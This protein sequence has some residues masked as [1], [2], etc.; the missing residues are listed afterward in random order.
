MESTKPIGIWIRVSTEDQAQGESPEHHEERARAYAK[1]MG[2]EVKTVYHL[3]AVSGKAVMHHNEAK[4]MLKDVKNGSITGLVFSKLARLARNTKELLEIADIF[5]AH[6]ASLISLQEKIDTG[7]AAG[8]LFYTIIAAMAQWEREEISSRVAASVQIRAQLGKPLGGAAPYGYRWKG[9]ELLL[10][11]H[12]APIRK[13]M[14][15]LYIV[16]KRKQVVCTILN[17]KGYRTRN[18]ALF[19]PTTLER[20]LRDPMAKGERRANYTKSLG[21]KKHWKVKD[22]SEWVM[23]SCPAIITE[24][25]YN[26]TIAILDQFTNKRTVRPKKAVYLFSGFL[27]CHCGGKMYVPSRT[28]KYVCSKCNLTSIA[29]SDI[30]EIYYENLKSF[31]LTKEDLETFKNRANEAIG[32]KKKLMDSLKKDKEK[33]K[34]EI[35]S[36][37]ILHKAGQIPTK[38]FKSHYDPLDLRLN[39]IEATL[40]E[41]EAQLDY[42]KLNSQNGEVI[43]DNAEN[44]YERWPALDLAVKRRIVEELTQSITIDKE[45]IEIVFGY[46]PDILGNTPNGER[47][48]KDS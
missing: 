28:Q 36:L 46:T 6:G 7:S 15:E 11:Q 19:T 22:A 29:I 47:N 48:L 32:E 35:S 43:L 25:M 13:M 4:R 34:D 37:L 3:E 39:Q 31:L 21:E 8:R 44:L 26:Q 12:E 20:L 33:I 24:D 16:H 18:G 14:Y 38:G 1:L 41:T 2:W 42:I 30:E 5:D 45:D 23:I 10:D 40:I 27:L 9:K 17:D